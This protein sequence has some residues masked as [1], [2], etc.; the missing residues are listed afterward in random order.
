MAT[1][2]YNNSNHENGRAQISAREILGVVFRRKIPILFCA[3]VVAAVA[4]TAASRTVSVYEGTV[5]VLL[6]RMGPTA[7]ATTWT[8]FFGL[9]EEMNTEVEIV[10]TTSVLHRAIELLE[11]RNIYLTES[12]GDS[13][14]TRQPTVDDLAAG[15]SAV[16]VEMSNV[17]L[18]RFRGSDPNF[19]AY[20]SKAVADAYVEHRVVVRKTGGIEEFFEEQLRKTEARLIGLK[21]HE[22]ALRKEGEIYDLEF[23][24]TVAIRNKGEFELQ[25]GETRS[26][27]IAEE[28]K[29]ESIK[30][31]LREDPDLLL[32]FPE[33][34]GD[35]LVN[36]MLASYWRLRASRDE[37]AAMFTDEN[38]QVQMEDERV[39]KM[40]SRFHDEVN[41]RMKEKEFYIEDLAAQ[42]AGLEHAI[43][44]VA[45]Q[46]RATPDIVARI[47]HVKKEIFYTYSHYDQLLEKLL[48]TVISQANDARVSNAKVIS[49]ATVSAT[50]AGRMKSVY[51]IFSILLGITLGVGFGFLLESL[52]HSMRSTEDIEGLLGVPV[53]GSIP[54]SGKLSD[55]A[56]RITNIDSE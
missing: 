47:E 26:E 4:L 41:R 50:V 53:L 35:R 43:A 8:P 51:V 23:Q 52:D 54:D 44:D 42:E 15:V 25:L 56:R 19:A 2:S 18:V 20:A 27:R 10:T 12:I 55:M 32:P 22:L 14:Y 7:L 6:R 30:R 5:K 39:E 11:E 21:E 3:V 33:F 24:Q 9:E 48:E 37:K 13:L 16:P 36:E 1:A 49:E 31:R 29:L 34:A 40:K 38:P 28:R 46:L 45:D 17:I